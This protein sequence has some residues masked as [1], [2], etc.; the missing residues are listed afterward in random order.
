VQTITQLPDEELA[1]ILL[2][3]TFGGSP[4]PYK[5]GVISKSICN[6][7]NALLLDNNWNP[8]QLAAPTSFPTK[9]ILDDD[10]PFGIG[11]N[12]IVDFPVDPWGML[13]VYLD[14]TIRLTVDLPD[15]DNADQMEC[16]PLLAIQSARPVDHQDPIPRNEMAA[17]AK[18]SAEGAL[19][20]QKIILGWYFDL[21]R[22][23][24]PL[25]ENK[26][27]AWTEKQLR[28]SLSN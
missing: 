16:A 25:P 7:A 6:L 4:G 17:K 11:R 21:W 1:I 3:L 5:W 23:T 14:D 10:I 9:Q 24:I 26:L 13:D 28:K 15:T 20:E 2:R 27:I 8:H 22:L 19:E 18:L 12:L